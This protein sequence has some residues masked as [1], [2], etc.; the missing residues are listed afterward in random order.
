MEPAL[1]EGDWI[2]VSRVDR[3]PHWLFR[4]PR[5]GDIVL[6]RD[7]RERARLVLKR[8]A[9]VHPDGYTLLGDRLDASTDSRTYGRV[10]PSDVVGR[11]IFRYA[12]LERVGPL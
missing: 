9:E 1:Q 3:G 12:P 8:V 10:A 11:A 4:A 6:A 5:P 7:P 2:I